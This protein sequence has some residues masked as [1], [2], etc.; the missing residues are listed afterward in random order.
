MNGKK[1]AWNGG[2]SFLLSRPIFLVHGSKYV[3]TGFGQARPVSECVCCVVFV[4][5][6]PDSCGHVVGCTSI[7][8]RE[9]GV[10][11]G[12][13]RQEVALSDNIV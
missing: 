4:L 12:S 7:S 1:D 13:P 11:H 9:A 5:L 2:G 3:I 8:V 6:R 10:Q